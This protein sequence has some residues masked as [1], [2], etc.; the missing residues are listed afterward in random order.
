M[1]CS[2]A[3]EPRTR[4]LTG[5]GYRMGPGPPGAAAPC[6]GPWQ[7][8]SAEYDACA[9]AIGATYPESGRRMDP[10]TLHASMTR[11]G[12]LRWPPCERRVSATSEWPTSA[13]AAAPSIPPGSR[14]PPS[15]MT[16]RG[17]GSTRAGAC[18]RCR[19]TGPRSRRR[20][21]TRS[22]CSASSHPESRRGA[23]SALRRRAVHRRPV[24]HRGPAARPHRDGCRH[25][26]QLATG[27]LRWADARD[28]R[29]RTR[30]GR[31][32]RPHRAPP[33]ALHSLSRRRFVRSAR[34]QGSE[35]TG[36]IIE[37][38]GSV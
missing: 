20:S 6:D 15:A 37:L 12:G 5:S 16:S 22:S 36:G 35:S 29:P 38:F 7:R 23:R 1:A 28:A 3:P 8:V 4:I 18:P 9:R 24:P 21:A 19:S 2:R 17:R 30:I 31:S 10:W 32:R 26:A 25:L 33:G 13:T 27:D 34:Q 11:P 14:T